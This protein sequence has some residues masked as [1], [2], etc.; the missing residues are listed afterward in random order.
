MNKTA[1]SGRV[2]RYRIIR[3]VGS[4]VQPGCILIDTNVALDIERF[5]FGAC[6]T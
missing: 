6:E 2:G 5:Y 3:A 1:W 4:E